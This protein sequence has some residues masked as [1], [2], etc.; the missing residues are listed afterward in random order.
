MKINGEFHLIIAVISVSPLGNM[1]SVVD[2]PNQ[3]SIENS[4]VSSIFRTPK[5]KHYRTCAV[6]GGND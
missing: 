3:A 4:I 6:N 2:S 1:N 5:R